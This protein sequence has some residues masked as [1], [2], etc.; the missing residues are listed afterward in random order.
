MNDFQF[1]LLILVDL[2][3]FK[4]SR[5]KN[6]EF[7]DI[8]RNDLFPVFRKLLAIDDDLNQANCEECDNEVGEIWVLVDEVR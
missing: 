2:G 7:F 8:A 4:I 5:V 1:L 3:F 6:S